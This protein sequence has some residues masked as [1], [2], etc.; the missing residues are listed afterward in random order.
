M[1][2]SAHYHFWVFSTF[3]HEPQ[4]KCTGANGSGICYIPESKSPR[5][6]HGLSLQPR[7]GGRK[8]EGSPCSLQRR[9]TY[10]WFTWRTGMLGRGHY[11]D[12]TEQLYLLL[13]EKGSIEVFSGEVKVTRP[14]ILASLFI[15]EP[16][17]HRQQPA[18]PPG[19]KKKSSIYSFQGA[20]TPLVSWTYLFQCRGLILQWG[21]GGTSTS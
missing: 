17:H 18:V 14:M 2:A 12:F 3:L 5:N 15:S 7:I 16:R 13:Q 20:F 4:R 1:T 11:V 19:S 6:K 21:G 10:S 8:E 9:S